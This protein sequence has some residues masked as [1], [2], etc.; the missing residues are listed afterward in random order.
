MASCNACVHGRADGETFGL[1]VAECAQAG[2][3]IFTFAHPPSDAA[4]HIKVLG[5]EAKLYE[6]KLD[7]LAQLRSF[8]VPAER[9]RAHVYR[10]LYDRFNAAVVMRTFLI[11]FDLL[12]DVA[13]GSKE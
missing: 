9:A 12:V 5:R 13:E 6:G 4:F 7:L 8:D 2:L 11:A 1:A 3:P 10:T